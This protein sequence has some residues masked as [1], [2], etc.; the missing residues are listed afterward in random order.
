MD[1]SRR[2]SDAFVDD[3][4]AL[5][6]TKHDDREVSHGDPGPRLEREQSSC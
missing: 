6:G 1:R 3:F 4:G 5:A 2:E